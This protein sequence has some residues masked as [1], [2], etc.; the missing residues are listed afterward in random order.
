MFNAVG[1]FG[2]WK[3]YTRHPKFLLQPST[4]YENISGKNALRPLQWPSREGVS[5]RGVHPPSR[6]QNGRRL[7]KHYLS[8]YQRVITYIQ[9]DPVETGP[10]LIH[11]FSEEIYLAMSSL[12]PKSADG[13]ELSSDL[14]HLLEVVC[15]SRTS[16]FVAFNKIESVLGLEWPDT[17]SLTV[18]G[19]MYYFP[20]VLKTNG[21]KCSLVAL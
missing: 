21:L 8:E 1:K 11:V 3:K 9:M 20:E 12:T 5:A 4:R 19:A 18:S 15:K 6:G 2:N 16:P 17:F 7:W 13:R 10:F 14:N